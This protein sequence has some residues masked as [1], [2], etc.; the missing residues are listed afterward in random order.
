ASSHCAGLPASSAPAPT[1]PPPRPDRFALSRGTH[2]VD[3]PALRSA[4]MELRLGRLF[5]YAASQEAWNQG[6]NQ[7]GRGRRAQEL[8]R[9]GRPLARH[10]ALPVTRWTDR[11]PGASLRYEDSRADARAFVLP[12]HPRSRGG[13]VGFLAEEG[14]RS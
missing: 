9:L 7:A 4:R 12:P 5:R 8:S 14:V 6:W 11:E 13:R 10:G 2:A 1:W 3:S